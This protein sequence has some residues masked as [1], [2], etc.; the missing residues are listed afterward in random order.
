TINTSIPTR[1][2]RPYS[3]DCTTMNAHTTWGDMHIVREL[4]ETD[5]DLANKEGCV[6]MDYLPLPNLKKYIHPLFD[7]KQFI[8]T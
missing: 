3:T 7:Q 5:V 4:P 1:W 8:N 2:H 6:D